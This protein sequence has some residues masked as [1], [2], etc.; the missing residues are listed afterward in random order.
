MPAQGLQNTHIKGVNLLKRQMKAAVK[1]KNNERAI[2]LRDSVF[3]YD[4]R[5][6]HF[7]STSK[8]PDNGCEVLGRKAMDWTS[9]N[10]RKA[11]EA[12]PMFEESIACL[13][14]GARPQS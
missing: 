12:R 1:A 10:K 9:L 4:L 2:A 14:T 11:I 5:I 7:P 3:H 8:K 6:A 13:K